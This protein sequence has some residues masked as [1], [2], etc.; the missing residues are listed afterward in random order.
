M[1]DLNDFLKSRKPVGEPVGPG[2]GGVPAAQQDAATR[3]PIGVRPDYLSPSRGLA[4][5]GNILLGD[6]PGARYPSTPEYLAGDEDVPGTWGGE[7]IAELQLAMEAA[8]LLDKPYQKGYWDA[9]SRQA[10]EQV[11]R[12]ANLT[13]QDATAALYDIQQRV[14]Q[15]GKTGNEQTRDPLFITITNPDQVAELASQIAVRTIG[16]RLSPD[17]ASRYAQTYN[18]MERQFQRQRYEATGSG[19]P[20]GPGGEAANPSAAGG[21]SIFAETQIRKDMPEEVTDQNYRNNFNSFLSLL[22]KDFG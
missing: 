9:K 5:S 16:R 7:A 13:G 3:P 6:K 8:G 4:D 15:F 2:A 10:Y 21:A 18:D 12:H 11:L 14:T 22:N 17:E 19:L 20:G 1:S